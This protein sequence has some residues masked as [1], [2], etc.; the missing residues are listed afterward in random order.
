MREIVFDTETTGLKP[1]EGHRIIEIGCVE[2][3]N[4]KITDNTF[5]ELLDP[6]R[7]VP[8]EITQITGLTNGDLKGKPTFEDIADTFLKFIGNDRIVAHNASFDVGFINNE[9]ELI[10]KPALTNPIIDTMNIAKEKFPG[11]RVNLDAL[12]NRFNI[13]KTEREKKGHGA[14]LDSQLLAEVYLKLTEGTQHNFFD[15]EDMK[16]IDFKEF[17]KE[18]KKKEKIKSRNFAI[19]EEELVSHQEFVKKNIKDN[20]WGY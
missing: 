15:D 2:M 14:L 6:E 19:A 13:D 3:I 1:Q 12:C 9:L 17:L 4:K 5:R 8:I 16:G 20:F 7:D 10:N 11:T 18:L